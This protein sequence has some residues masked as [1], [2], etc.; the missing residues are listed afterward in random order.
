LALPQ[1]KPV[2][3]PVRPR[4][5]P[6]GFFSDQHARPIKQDV[7]LTTTRA[8]VQHDKGVRALIGEALNLVPSVAQLGVK[9]AGRLE[10]QRVSQI[11]EQLVQR[12]DNGN[13]GE[14]SLRDL[15]IPPPILAGERRLG[16]LL[17]GAVTVVGGATGKAALPQV[18]VDPASEV[19]PQ[20]RTRFT[21]GLVDREV[22]RRRKR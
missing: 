12:P 13:R 18:A 14:H 21:G 2:P 5:P 9:R 10:R 15:W 8:D 6:A 11:P 19:R 7:D 3:P 22:G 20:V 16:D 17:P 1:T 4:V